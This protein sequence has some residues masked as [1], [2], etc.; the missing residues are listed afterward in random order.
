M[1]DGLA[2][3][4]IATTIAL[5]L[6]AGVLAGV[7]GSNSRRVKEIACDHR[8]GVLLLESGDQY[9]CVRRDA[10]IEYHDQSENAK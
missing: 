1:S 4:A 7:C 3:Y 5:I 9:A 2:A 8:G 6:L 10:M